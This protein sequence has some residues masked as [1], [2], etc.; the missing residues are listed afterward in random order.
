[1][2]IRNFP[3]NPSPFIN[4]ISILVLSFLILPSTL[5]YFSLSL[6]SLPFILFLLFSPPF[7]LHYLHI[8]NVT[9]WLSPRILKTNPP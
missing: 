2:P 9:T 3:Y 6:F 4:L 1:M 7:S 5:I 8:L